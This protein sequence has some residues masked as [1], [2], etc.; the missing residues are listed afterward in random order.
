MFIKFV[1][2]DGHEFRVCEAQEIAYNYST[3]SEGE[4][5]FAI[6][7]GKDDGTNNMHVE[8][9]TGKVVVPMGDGEGKIETRD[10]DINGWYHIYLMNNK[11][12]TI[13]KIL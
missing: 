8:I 7:D 12:K 13:E 9:K 5:I 4:E 6:W 1:T 11:G 3:N 10:R 2:L